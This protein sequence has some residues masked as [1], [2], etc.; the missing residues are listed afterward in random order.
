M[1][2]FFGISEKYVLLF[3]V[4]SAPKFK[5]NLYNPGF[6]L[7]GNVH[8]TNPHELCHDGQ[9]YG[10]GTTIRCI[11]VNTDYCRHMM[12]TYISYSP[13]K[14]IPAEVDIEETHQ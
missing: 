3:S 2:F 1:S 9:H 11:E 6:L 14:I 8:D 5:L 7:L 4:L 13:N 10:G 12:T